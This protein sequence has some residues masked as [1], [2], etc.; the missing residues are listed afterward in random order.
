MLDSPTVGMDQAAKHIVW[1]E[2][3]KIKK[4]KIVI[5][6]TNDMHEAKNLADRVGVIDNG[7]LAFCGSWNFF[8]ENTKMAPKIV[9]TFESEK[10]QSSHA[11]KTRIEDL[12]FELVRDP[13]K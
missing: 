8:D 12:I 2:I 3:L 13:Y 5:I 11:D 10:T 1:R 6:A 7:K 4:D 9:C